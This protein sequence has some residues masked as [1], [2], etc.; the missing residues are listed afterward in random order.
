MLTI[1][2]LLC[3]CVLGKMFF[4]QTLLFICFC[5]S[6]AQDQSKIYP[7]QSYNTSLSPPPNSDSPPAQEDLGVPRKNGS[8]EH[9]VVNFTTATS[10]TITIHSG[11]GGESPLILP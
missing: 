6:T 4:D 11:K 7:S 1:I 3:D 2:G 10:D 5:L 9:T 8:Q